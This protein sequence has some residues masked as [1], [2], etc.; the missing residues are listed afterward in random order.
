MMPMPHLPGDLG[1]IFA[2]EY[3]YGDRPPVLDED[4]TFNA[5][6]TNFRQH[7]TIKLLR[8]D[9]RQAYRRHD[10]HLGGTFD[11]LADKLS[12][13]GRHQHCGSLGCLNCLRATQRAKAAASIECIHTMNR[14]QSASKILTMVTCIPVHLRHQP[15]DLANANVSECSEW[16]QRRLTEE[17]FARPMLGS[18]DISWEKN[19]YQLHWHFATW[20]SNPSKLRQ[21]LKSIFPSD[22]R[23]ARPV[24]VKKARDLDFLTYT[25]KCIKSVDLLR[26]NRRGLSHLL[27]MLDRTNPLDIMLLRGLRISFEEGPLRIVQR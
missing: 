2:N 15:A 12:S 5:W 13:C 19:F 9:A 25:H 21:R 11:R 3:W 20:T 16:L 17:G 10:D 26:R 7:Q 18:L 4:Q 22:R 8:R 23:Y 1:D 27:V 14:G 6:G 24:Y